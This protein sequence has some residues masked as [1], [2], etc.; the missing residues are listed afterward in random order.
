MLSNKDRQAVDGQIVPKYIYI[1]F[2]TSVAVSMGLIK[3]ATTVIYKAV[4]AFT[5][6]GF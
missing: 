4:S 5:G 1:F 6:G 2:G 3:L